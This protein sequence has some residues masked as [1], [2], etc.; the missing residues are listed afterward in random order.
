[1]YV[2]LVIVRVSWRDV[3][4]VK[5][6]DVI[7]DYC[8]NVMGLYVMGRLPVLLT[9]LLVYDPILTTSPTITFSTLK[10]TTTVFYSPTPSIHALKSTLGT[11]YCG[12]TSTTTT[13]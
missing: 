13:D 3:G 10:L 8:C 6:D 1:M 9:I 7:G 12:T 5:R 11:I 2:G 4:D